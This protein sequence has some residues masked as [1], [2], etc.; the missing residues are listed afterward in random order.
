MLLNCFY[1]AIITVPSVN[2][3]QVFSSDS[4]L[5]KTWVKA[6]AGHDQI[7]SHVATQNLQPQSKIKREYL[8]AEHFRANEHQLLASIYLYWLC[9]LNLAISAAVIASSAQRIGA[10]ATVEDRSR[11][12]VPC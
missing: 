1:S 7:N 8:F 10:G 5:N 2:R 4:L 12:S 11:K 9:C 3:L 6:G